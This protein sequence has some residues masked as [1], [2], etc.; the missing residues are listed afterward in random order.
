MK[1]IDYSAKVAISIFCGADVAQAARLMRD[2]H[3]GFLV[4]HREGDDL[5]RPLGVLTDRD[6]VLEV[7]ACGIDPRSVTVED[8]MTREPLIARDS[9]ELSDV[10]QTMRREGV[11]RVPVVDS[12]GAL[13]GIIAI[14][15]L[16]GIVAGLICDMAGSIRTEQR[17]EWRSCVA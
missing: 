8:V 9:D 3:V 7:T 1:V 12:R 14:D 4:V 6:I 11:R 17:R 16:V 2:Q 13:V 5:R 10:L 15:D